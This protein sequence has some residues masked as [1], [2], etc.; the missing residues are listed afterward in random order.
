MQKSLKIALVAGE[1]SG[2]VL[3]A[4]LIEALKQRYPQ[5]EFVGVGGPKMAAAGCDNW[6]SYE[7]LAVMGLFEIVK[8]LPRLIKF[9]KTLVKQF[10]EAAPDVFIGIDAPD[11]NLGLEKRLHSVGIKTVHYVSPSVWAWR[12]SRV[13]TVAK[14]VDLML[15]LLPFEAKFYEEHD[16]PVAFVGHPLADDIAEP[17]RAG[18]R[19]QLGLPANAPIVAL[20][21]GSRRGEIERLGEPF[22]ATARWL[23]SQLSD[24]EFLLPCASPKLRPLLEQQQKDTGPLPIH[25]LDADAQTAMAAADVVLMASGTATLEALLLKRPMVVAYAMS[26][27]SYKVLKPLVKLDKYSLPN[28]LISSE[29]VEE[30][31]QDDV[32]PERMGQAVYDLLTRPDQREAMVASFDAV[33]NTLR[34]NASQK[35]ADAIEKHILNG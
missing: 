19:E 33:H 2:D 24:V 23:Q 30:F 11:F 4:G 14:S 5:A 7:E 31:I 3:G 34:R 21:P 27:L 20:L 6:H 28:L 9:R 35:A 22:L 16:V 1:A 10:T 13:K 32:V 15:T 29:P 26:P 18:A 12:Q 25:I 17:D 8:H